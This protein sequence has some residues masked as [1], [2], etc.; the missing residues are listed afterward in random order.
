[1]RIQKSKATIDLFP[2]RKIIILVNNRWLSNSL[3]ESTKSLREILGKNLLLLS[4]LRHQKDVSIV[5]MNERDVSQ[6][7]RG[8][9]EVSEED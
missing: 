8:R 4:S 3:L 7:T 2:Y 1:M 5:L 9:L 6:G